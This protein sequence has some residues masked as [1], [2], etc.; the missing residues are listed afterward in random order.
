MEVE[1]YDPLMSPVLMD[2]KKLSYEDR[3][4][5]LVDL[6]ANLDELVSQRSYS[7][8]IVLNML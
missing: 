1:E 5:P 2:T 8:C 7:N 3:Q 4:L 6:Q